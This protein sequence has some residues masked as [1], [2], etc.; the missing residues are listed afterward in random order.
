MPSANKT[1]RLL[2][3]LGTANPV[4]VKDGPAVVRGIQ[5]A[6]VRTTA[7]HL[8]LYDKSTTPASTDTPR[9]TLYLPA[10]QAFAFDLDVSLDNGLSFRMTTAAADNDTG[11]LT[12]GDVLNLNIDY[13]SA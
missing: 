13:F 3:A 12:A 4:V 11:V 1:Y 5:G 6:N 8:K 9:K 7:V 10:G 2:S